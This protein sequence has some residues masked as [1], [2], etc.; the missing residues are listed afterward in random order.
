MLHCHDLLISIPLVA[1]LPITETLQQFLMACETQ[2]AGG[3]AELVLW[4][5]TEKAAGIL[6]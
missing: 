5:F 1:S 6:V 4:V 3:V 2:E